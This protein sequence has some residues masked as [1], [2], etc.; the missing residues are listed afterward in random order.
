[1]MYV[2]VRPELTP[3]GKAALE[4]WHKERAEIAAKEE[5]KQEKLESAL[6]NLINDAGGLENFLA[7]HK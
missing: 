6:E 2:L 5:K 3:E 4:K 7:A 1:M